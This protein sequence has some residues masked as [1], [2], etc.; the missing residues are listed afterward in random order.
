MHCP[1]EGILVC[2]KSGGLVK[3]PINSHAK[4][5]KKLEGMEE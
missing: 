5:R 4:K 3:N 1:M 2:S